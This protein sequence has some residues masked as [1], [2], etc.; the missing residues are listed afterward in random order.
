MFLNNCA[1][2]FVCAVTDKK[3]MK[4]WSS[5]EGQARIG[6]GWPPRRKASKLKPEPRAVET[7]VS[8]RTKVTVRT[9]MNSQNPSSFRIYFVEQLLI[10]EIMRIKIHSI[11][12]I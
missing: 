7:L 4:L 5:G 1:Q 12:T 10:L 9:S 6:K 3:D 11:Y 2:D 8:E